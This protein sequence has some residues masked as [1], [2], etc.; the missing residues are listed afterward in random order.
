MD[1]KKKKIIIYIDG[2]NFY[3][4]VKKTFECR[5]DIERFCKKLVGKNDLIKI[6][7][8]TSPVGESNPLGYSEQQRFFERLKKIDNLNIILGRLEKHKNEGKFIYVEKATDINIAQDLIFDSIDNLYDEAYLVSND[9][10]FSGVINSIIN[11]YKKRIIYVAIG[12]RKSI[13][14]HLKK[15]ASY[16]LN[17]NGDFISD[18]KIC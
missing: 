15:V 18:I 10:D 2:S 7:Y 4:S 3:F 14:Y 12:N 8:Y 5:I 16:T 17:I 11:R 6:N 9:G 13:S 1:S